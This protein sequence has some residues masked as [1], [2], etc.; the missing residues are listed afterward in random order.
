MAV[1]I[2]KNDLDAIRRHGEA[3]YPDE[4][5]GFLLGKPNGA[6]RRVV[7]LFPAEN[8]R[9]K[10][11]R[12]NRFEI[13]P[14]E[15]IRVDKAARARGLDVV[16][17]YHSH[18]NAPAEPSEFDRRH[19]WPWYSYIIVSIRDSAA[20]ELTS[21]VLEDNRSAF[22]QEEIVTIETRP[23]QGASSWA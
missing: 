18:P 23:E 19:A 21:W 5:C 16:G 14:E 20:R 2:S 7:E 15:Y 4:C 13:S 10:E 11:A 12:F 3:T 17:F 8:I 6:G 1:E 9:E 22:T